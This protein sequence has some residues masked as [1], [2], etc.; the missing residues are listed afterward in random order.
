MVL[1]TQSELKAVQ[2]HL[3]KKSH[4][5]KATKSTQSATY[6]FKQPIKRSESAA[7]GRTRKRQGITVGR[8][9]RGVEVKIA[10]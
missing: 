5:K 9:N 6:V 7:V 2:A 8:S 1:P 10:A 4:P 3:K